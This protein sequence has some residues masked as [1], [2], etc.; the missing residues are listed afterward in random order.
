M[1]G[2]TKSPFRQD[3]DQIQNDL[4]NVTQL[5]GG[6]VDQT[7]VNAAYYGARDYSDSNTN[8]WMKTIG[9]AATSFFSAR[10]VRKAAKDAERSRLMK[11]LEANALAVYTNS[12]AMGTEFFNIAFEHVEGIKNEFSQAVKDKDTKLQA[13]L[14][15]EL[16]QYANEIK[17]LKGNINENAN[18]VHE[19]MLSE[20]LSDD[21]MKIATVCSTQSNARFLDTDE[22]GKKE[23]VWE[24]PEFR[25][26]QNETDIWKKYYNVE[27]Y[28]GVMVLRDEK[29]KEEI[30]L[31]E[32]TIKQNGVNFK[33]GKGGDIFNFDSYRL[34]NEERITEEN[35]Q[36]LM[37]DNIF[38]D[39]R[40]KDMVHKDPRLKTGNILRMMNLDG[41][42]DKNIAFISLYDSVD[43][44]KI[45]IEDFMD[46]GAVEDPT[47]LTPITPADVEVLKGNENIWRKMVGIAKDKM[48]NAILDKG[49]GYDF[50][51]SKRLLADFMTGRQESIFW[52]DTDKNLDPAEY[53]G[54]DLSEYEGAKGNIGLLRE[55]GATVDDKN[56]IIIVNRALYNQRK[57]NIGPP[58]GQG[59]FN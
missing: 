56:R 24:N 39:V 16:N 8:N 44:G 31:E 52:G 38:N 33:S 32:G 43:D 14:K 36:S 27:D 1:A 41:N 29:T 45:G 3:K 12:G 6:K 48:V 54:K 34:K 58:I 23:W 53:V 37:H 2:K 15:V 47:P 7:L 5:R 13:S 4:K 42:G 51:L 30:L 28:N 17:S 35:I 59:E 11:T 46:F 50:N 18:S 21:Q 49:P 10:Q 26:G 57:A 19:D 25:E 9:S 20:G 40:F 55:W 22:D